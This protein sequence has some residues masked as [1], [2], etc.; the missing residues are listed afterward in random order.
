MK[1][2]IS[3]GATLTCDAPRCK[4]R[5][6]SYSVASIVRVQAQLAEWARVPAWQVAGLKEGGGSPARADRV[7]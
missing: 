3:N 2:T 6:L 4:G 5:F 7:S 1:I